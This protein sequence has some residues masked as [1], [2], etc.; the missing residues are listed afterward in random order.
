MSAV[1]YRADSKSSAL[2]QALA[3]GLDELED[4]K[5]GL[6]LCS[7]GGSGILECVMS[8]KIVTYC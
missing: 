4:L 7:H 6:A 2:D 1:F 5:R 8:F 3:L